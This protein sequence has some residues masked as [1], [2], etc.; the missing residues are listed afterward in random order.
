MIVAATDFPDD[1][2]KGEEPYEGL[3]LEVMGQA[4]AMRY[5]PND[6]EVYKDVYVDQNYPFIVD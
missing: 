3:R 1:G 5:W 2:F 4:S 6:D